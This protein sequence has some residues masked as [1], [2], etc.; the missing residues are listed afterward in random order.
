MRTNIA[1]N[2]NNCNNCNVWHPYAQEAVVD[3]V[4]NYAHP[5]NAGRWTQAL[6]L[7]L[8][9][10]V[11]Y[12]RKRA[13]SNTHAPLPGDVTDR[14]AAAA[15]RLVD[16]GMYSKNSTMR[17]VAASAAAQLAYVRPA[18]VLPK[19]MARFV[20]AVEHTTATHQLGRALQHHPGLTQLDR[21]WFQRLTP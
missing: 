2:S 16:K 13:V 12:M 6:A 21:A 7:F 11:K 15:M 5:S 1:F 4:E 18:V 14:I 3:V 9:S 10:L 17:Y 19:V 8:Q 20:E